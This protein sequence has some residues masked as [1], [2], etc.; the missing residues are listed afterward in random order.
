MAQFEIEKLPKGNPPKFPVD[1]LILVWGAPNPHMGPRDIVNPSHAAYDADID[2]KDMW[3]LSTYYG[4]K[5]ESMVNSMLVEIDGILQG[6]RVPIS[7]AKDGSQDGYV[8]AGRWRTLAAREAQKRKPGIVI[9]APFIWVPLTDAAIKRQM[10]LENMNGNRNLK[11]T[12]KAAYVAILESHGE[13]VKRSCP[14]AGFA[15]GKQ[16]RISRS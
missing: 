1:Q 12:R 13:P 10:V 11:P 8:V 6:I 7:V 3:D 4:Q 2:D 15:V 16:S 9:H 14:L 5:F